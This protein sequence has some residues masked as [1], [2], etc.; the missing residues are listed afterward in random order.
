[1]FIG[2]GTVRTIQWD[3]GQTKRIQRLVQP[4]LDHRRLKLA[5]SY[6][7]TQWWLLDG[8]Q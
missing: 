4:L 3:R 6:K 8:C 5:A 2:P 1:M 7:H